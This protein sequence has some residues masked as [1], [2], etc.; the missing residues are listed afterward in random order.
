MASR[1]SLTEHDGSELK[2]VKDEEIHCIIGED[3][4]IRRL[5]YIDCCR[6]TCSTTSDVGGHGEGECVELG[7]TDTE[8]SL[9]YIHTYACTYTEVVRSVGTPF[10]PKES[11]SNL[12]ICNHSTELEG[13]HSNPRSV[14]L[15][16]EAALSL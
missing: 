13:S 4:K 15:H 16:P 2:Y 11:H 9:G 10:M 7:G 12:S 8:Q 1:H 5:E 3:L 6:S 14:G